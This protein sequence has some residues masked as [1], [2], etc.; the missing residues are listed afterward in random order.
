MGD[1]EA[2]GGRGQ[3][4]AGRAQLGASPRACLR[5]C[6]TQT[7]NSERDTRRQEQV[8]AGHADPWLMGALG[9]GGL[10]FPRPQRSKG[11]L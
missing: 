11:N 2:Q 4:E 9:L 6:S 10:W 5:L 3:G 1:L 7:V 8:P